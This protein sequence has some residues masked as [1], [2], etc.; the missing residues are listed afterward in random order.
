MD[1]ADAALHYSDAMD[2]EVR[3]ASHRDNG[4]RLVVRSDEILTAFLEPERITHESAL[5]SLLGD[6]THSFMK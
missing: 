6:G 3:A 5:S 2:A 4:Q 1:S